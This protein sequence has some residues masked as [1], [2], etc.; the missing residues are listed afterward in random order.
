MQ[1]RSSEG[2]QFS[3]RPQNLN[4][5]TQIRPSFYQKSD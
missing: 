1:T 5:Q 3:I 4:Y 2:T